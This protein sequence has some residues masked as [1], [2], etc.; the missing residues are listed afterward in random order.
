MTDTQSL[1]SILSKEDANYRKQSTFQK[2]H[3]GQVNITSIPSKV[4]TVYQD[5]TKWSTCNMSDMIHIKQ[6]E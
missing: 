4:E 5:P 2:Q 6:V 3:Q 1:V